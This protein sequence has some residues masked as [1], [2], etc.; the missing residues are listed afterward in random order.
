MMTTLSLADLQQQAQATYVY[1]PLWLLLKQKRIQKLLAESGVDTHPEIQRLRVFKLPLPDPIAMTGL[2]E[3]H[4]S[5][6]SELEFD[7]DVKGDV[8]FF[9]VKRDHTHQFCLL[10]MAMADSW[11]LDYAC[12]QFREMTTHHTPTEVMQSALRWVG[13]HH[14]LPDRLRWHPMETQPEPSPDGWE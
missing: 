13:C 6:T 12:H 3:S 9:C 1:W 5:D 8:A 4:V 14:I 2:P 11:Y 7:V 10:Q